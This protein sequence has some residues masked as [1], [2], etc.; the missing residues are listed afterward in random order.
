MPATQ[1]TTARVTVRVRS[2]GAPVEGAEVRAGSERRQEEVAA[3][4]NDL[5][6]A[7][8]DAD[9]IATLHLTPGRYRLTVQRL[10]FERLQVGIRAGSDTVVTVELEPEPIELADLIV[11][12]TRSERPIEEEPVRVEA[13]PREEIDENTALAPGNLTMVLTDLGGVRIQATAPALG[14][15]QVRLLG[16]NGRYTRLLTDGLPLYGGQLSSFSVTQVPPIDLARV[17]VIK[18]TASALYGGAALGGVVNLVSRR[19]AGG[20]E[21]LVNRTSREGTDAVAFLPGRLGP[22]WG[23]TLL[24]TA[25]DQGQVD[26]DGDDWLDLSGYRRAVIRPRIFWDPGAG[27]SLFL[28]LGGSI[29]ERAGGTATGATLP[30][31]NGYREERDTRRG[32][33]GLVARFLLGSGQ[34]IAVRAAAMAER[35]DHVH[36]VDAYDDLHGT[37]FGEVTLGRVARDHR[38]VVGA[39]YQEDRYRSDDLP[40]FVYT[41]RA[42]A[43]FAQDVWEPTAWFTLSGS[44]RTDF[45]D[46]YGT[47]L[48]PKLSALLRPGGGWAVRASASLGFAAP[49][50]FVERVEEIGLTRLEPLADLEAERARSASFDLER[51][52][53]SLQ[54]TLSL[55]GTEI[56]HALLVRESLEAPGQ[57]E[58]AN[59]SRPTRAY[60]LEA[61]ARYLRGPVYVLASHTYLRSREDAPNG[62]RRETPLTPR[63][64]FMVDAV[65][66]PD[67]GTRVG[68]EGA[69]V[70]R[71]QL[72][73]DDPFRDES[74]PYV[75]LGLL[76]E[77]RFGAAGLFVNIENILDV[78]QTRW[79]PLVRP[80][81]ASDGRWT[82]DI[83]APLEGRMVNAGVRLKL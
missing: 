79:N 81:R 34:I 61:R 20:P 33:A 9:G 44:A 22:D 77:H 42:P 38:W 8:S 73:E 28:T 12:A 67:E 51:E 58:L 19:P 49:T 64:L 39:A 26:V 80:E 7:I 45:H 75:I 53:G 74:R 30:D 37:W 4:R 72:E 31:G 21:F 57:V 27:R 48:S 16:L 55:F 65:I 56:E 70:G 10:G 50:P 54:L 66:E 68:I 59:A 46:E 47:F 40:A 52:T 29:E 18:G 41:Y 24:A 69:Y 11:T 1:D 14:G 83:W 15:A 60:G 25:H 32:D 63:H 17:E 43:L 82:T 6:A 76:A 78:R 5:S 36:G 23:Y 2:E 3:A 35:H 71:Q 13:L 62:G